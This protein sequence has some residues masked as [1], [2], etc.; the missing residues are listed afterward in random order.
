VVKAISKWLS[1]ASLISVTACGGGGGGGS[2]GGGGGSGGAGGDQ[3]AVNPAPPPVPIELKQSLGSRLF[4]DTN[5]STPPGQACASC[6]DPAAGF[7]DPD[8][9][10]PVSQGVHI[11]RFGNRNTPTIAYA[12]FSPEFQGDQDQG[13]VGG[14]FLDGRSANLVEQAKQPFLNPVEMANPDK[15]TVIQAVRNS[16]YANLFEQVYGAGSLDNTEAAFDQIA[17]AIAAFENS[18][19]VSPFTS[20]FDAFLAGQVALT[21]QETRGLN[22]F[23]GIGQ[24]ADCHLLPLFTDHTYS[25]LGVPRNPDNPFYDQ[26]PEFNPDGAA[27]VDLGLAANPRVLL[28]S[29]NGK[30]KV[31]TLRNVAITPP[32]MH[33]GVF[34]TLEEVVNFYNTRDV[35]PQCDP[36]GIPGMNC[37]PAPEVADN[38]D[39]LRMGNLGLSSQEVADVVAFLQTLTDG[40]VPP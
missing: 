25:N 6:H 5:L 11:D 32:Y 16:D 7:A 17:D 40:F 19:E 20:K 22:V 39:T 9:N 34:Q 37:W 24:C 8:S 35:L 14:Q 36:A 12:G 23:Q 13:F 10:V 33:N 15:L 29:E 31:P 18:D 27:F 3:Q 38:V 30:F 2:G 21:A 28:P 1:V 26:P 4:F